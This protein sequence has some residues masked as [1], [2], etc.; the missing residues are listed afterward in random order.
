MRRPLP[1]LGDLEH[2]LLTLLWKHGAMT[3]VAVRNALNRDLKDATIRTV[4]RRLE[5]KRYVSHTVDK[6][7]FI[8]TAKETQDRAAAKAVKGIVDKF[9]GGSLERMLLGLVEA[10]VIQP[11]QL[12]ALVGKVTRSLKTR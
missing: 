1:P 3:A 12:D 5:E 6:G 9:C 2:E 8:Y 7:T 11:K 4:L 10:S